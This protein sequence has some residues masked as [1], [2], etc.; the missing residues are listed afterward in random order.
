[1]RTETDAILSV[2]RFFAGVLAEPWEVVLVVEGGEDPVRPY[3][4]VE[5]LE[6]IT[7]EGPPAMQ[8]ITMPVVANLY[9]EPFE[10]RKAAQQGARDLRELVWQAVKWGPGAHLPSQ[11][12]TTDRIPLYDYDPE[13]VPVGQDVPFHRRSD[14]MRVESFAQ[15]THNEDAT[16]REVQ[17]VVDLRLT[18]IRGLPLPSGQRQLQRIVTSPEISDTSRL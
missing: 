5:A 10:T 3:A 11:R 7:T 9:P 15:R 2:Q 8:Q 18:F 17:V 14:Y 12:P 13:T 4:T 1:M 6:N 16:P